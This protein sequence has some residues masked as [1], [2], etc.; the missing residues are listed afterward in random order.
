MAEVLRTLDKIRNHYTVFE[1]DQVL[2]GGQLNSVVEYLDDQ[3][4]LTRVQLLGV[5]IVCGL[6]ASLAGD[7][8]TLTRGLGVTTDGDLI[9]VAA[10]TVFTHFKKYGDPAPAPE[11]GPFNPVAG[12]LALFE[13]SADGT[14]PGVTPLAQFP[15]T[16]KPLGE[17]AA[18]LFVE[19]QKSDSDL[20]T[21]TDCDNLGQHATHDVKLLFLD[22]EAAAA[23]KDTVRT[24]DSAARALSDEVVA[25]RALPSA[26]TS[27]EA[28]AQVYRGAC[29]KIHDRLANALP[30]LYKE[31]APFLADVFPA[32]S[33]HGWIATLTNIRS[34]FT[35]SA[36]GIQYY[37][38]FLKDV[39]DT[40]LELRDKL[41]GDTTVCSPDPNAFPKHLLLG[42]VA[43]TPGS[44]VTRTGFY[45][46]A[47]AAAGRGRLGHVRFLAA[48]LQALFDT[49]KLPAGAQPIRI[50]PSHGEDR[51]LEE[52]AIPYYYD[53]SHSTGIHNRWNYTLAARDMSA[54][55]YSYNA[56]KYGGR[57][58][59]RQ[60]LAF[61][62]GRFPFFR[63]EGHVGTAVADAVAV[64][65]RAIKDNNLPFAVRPVLLGSDRKNVRVKL[66]PRWTDLHRFHHLVRHTVSQELAQVMDF[67]GVFD[68]RVD[69]EVTVDLV[70]DFA[71]VKGTTA[72]KTAAVQ[73]GASKTKAVLEKSYA[74]FKSDSSWRN[75]A[76]ETLTA[77]E[78]SSSW[79][80]KSRRPM[81]PHRSTRW[82]GASIC[83]GST[84][85]TKSSSPRRRSRTSGS[86]TPS[87]SPSTRAWSIL[88]A[89]AGVAPWCWFTTMRARCSPTSCSLISAARRPRSPT[90][91]S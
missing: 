1:D 84:G 91:R 88:A 56:D 16:P 14:A 34:A 18:V 68:Q 50:T 11:Y 10:D 33:H 66:P 61:Q 36:L 58:A 9:Q 6:R 30:K 7:K 74:A 3:S 90:S 54:D 22:K 45:P 5:G 81:C 26:I 47:V 8:V 70:E 43:G 27:V 35:S 53:A 82:L 41:F 21:S 25:A 13:L 4:R 44:A 28:L 24:P 32:E 76:T 29:Q 2:T 87:C 49:F 46:S 51:S 78:I 59:A 12:P 23:L 19:S 69:R 86:S 79:S 62:M 37:Y 15:T 75:T 42:A 77:V 67:G 17:M 60:P 39:V 48:K 31:C 72:T 57:D 71:G 63:I 40:Y 55:N 52:R 80:E 85:W 64:L 73:A 65:E 83:T 20:C 38:D 89:C